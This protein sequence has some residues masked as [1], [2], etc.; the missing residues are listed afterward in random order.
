MSKRLPRN[1]PKKRSKSGKKG[2]FG[3]ILGSFWGFGPSEGRY[4]Q[5][6]KNGFLPF[7]WV[8]LI[9]RLREIRYTTYSRPLLSHFNGDYRKT[10][11]SLKSL[12]CPVLALLGQNDPKWPQI[13]LFWP[14]FGGILNVPCIIGRF[15]ETRKRGFLRMVHF[16]VWGPFDPLFGPL[17]E[18]CFPVLRSYL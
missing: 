16:G 11:K 12:K 18:G 7:F 5:K 1:R 14:L 15:W 4:T 9:L 17:L 6:A 8:F 10:P 2:Y 13:G 3:V